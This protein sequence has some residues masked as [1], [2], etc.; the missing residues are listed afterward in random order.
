M[1]TNHIASSVTSST[2][3]PKLG[4]LRQRLNNS[5]LH[6]SSLAN[7]WPRARPWYPWCSCCTLQTSPKVFKKKGWERQED[8]KKKQHASS[9]SAFRETL[10][11]EIA[12]E[13]TKSLAPTNSASTATYTRRWSNDVKRGLMQHDGCPR[14][15]P[16][17][18]MDTVPNPSSESNDRRATKESYDRKLHDH[19]DALEARRRCGAA[20][21]SGMRAEHLKILLIDVP[22]TELLAFGATRLANAGGARGHHPSPG[23]GT[24]HGAPPGRGSI[25]ANVRFKMFK[26]CQT[27]TP[28]PPSNK[29]RLS[30][31]VNCQLSSASID[32]KLPRKTAVVVNFSGRL[33]LGSSK[34]LTFGLA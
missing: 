4:K 1:I 21:L 31:A 2:C 15:R 18:N 17:A 27:K 34:F 10:E 8:R 22:A 16:Q 30:T 20:G 12:V 11:R 33:C 28:V 5:S 32:Q 7:V 29:A 6:S 13:E 9:K 24:P 23:L 19:A 25:E 26:T 3:A 14:R